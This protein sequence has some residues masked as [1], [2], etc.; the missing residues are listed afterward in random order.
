MAQPAAEVGEPMPA[1]SDQSDAKQNILKLAQG[2]VDGSVT[3]EDFK[4]AIQEMFTALEPGT[5][6]HERYY[7]YFA[8]LF[9]GKSLQDVMEDQ[10]NELLSFVSTI[11]LQGVRKIENGEGKNGQSGRDGTTQPN[12]SRDW[13]LGSHFAMRSLLLR[14][15][16]LS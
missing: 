4:G 12:S 5:L 3:F 10:K 13:F 16:A 2:V 9:K 11:V 15:S 8:H 7:E 1:P 14:D 6:Y